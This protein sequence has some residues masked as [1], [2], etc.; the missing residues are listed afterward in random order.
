[1]KSLTSFQELEALG[2]GLSK[3]YITKTH[4][5]NSRCFDIEGFVKEYLRLAVIYEFFA[6]DDGNRIGFLA[7][8]KDPLKVRRSGKKLSIV[9][10]KDTI[11]IEKKLL[12][13]SES[14]RRRFTIAHE[15]A[16]KILELHVPMQ[17][18]PVFHTDYSY[19]NGQKWD[20]L[21]KTLS[22]NEAFANRLGA[23]VLMPGFLIAK[24][25]KKYNDGR[26][27][28]CYDGGIFS[29]EDKL[30]IQRM[31]NTLGVSYSAFITRLKELNLIECR[32]IEEYIESTLLAGDAV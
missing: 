9:F 14:S 8:G 32:P 18:A 24:T 29:Q 15:A 5:W 30:N 1:M 21:K 19:G 2:E 22:L 7:N 13:E 4:R 12:Q 11:V 27:I 20:D 17:A 6:E 10:P 28:R 25:L 23:V 31:A 26:T 3:A 16:H